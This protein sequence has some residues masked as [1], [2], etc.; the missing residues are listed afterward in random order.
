MKGRPVP[1]RQLPADADD[2]RIHAA[3]KAVEGIS[4]QAL[5]SGLVAEALDELGQIQ[6]ALALAA[7]LAAQGKD[8]SRYFDFAR[9]VQQ[10]AP[11]V[12]RL[13]RSGFHEYLNRRYEERTGESLDEPGDIVLT[14]LR[15]REKRPVIA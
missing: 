7:R 11:I 12:Q 8:P 2:R 4:T 15:D 10:A 14:P 9:A 6:F 3:L 13:E 5:E 1:P